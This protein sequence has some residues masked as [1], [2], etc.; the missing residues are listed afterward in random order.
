MT[1][2]ES[3][4]DEVVARVNAHDQPLRMY[5][6]CEPYGP[7]YGKRSRAVALAVKRGLIRAEGFTNRRVFMRL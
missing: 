5:D 4:I 3:L 6:I 1:E 7:W 2:L